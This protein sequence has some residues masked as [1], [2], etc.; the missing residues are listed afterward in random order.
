MKTKLGK[1]IG[2]ILSMLMMFSVAACGDKDKGG[3]GTDGDN[4]GTGP[5][6]PV[7]A[8]ERADYLAR[9]VD[10]HYATYNANGDVAVA[11]YYNALEGG[12]DGL[13]NCYEYS[14]MIDMANY[15]VEISAGEDKTYYTKLLN[16]YVDGLKFFRGSGNQTST[17]G[18]RYWEKLHG[19]QRK[20]EPD[21]GDVSGINLVYDDLMWI[22]RD[23]L[24]AYQNTGDRK[25]VTEAEYLTMNCLDGWDSTKGGIGGITWGPGYGSK[26]SCSNAPIIS[27]LSQLAEIY[28][29][30]DATVTAEETVFT[31]QT[32]GQDK[33]QWNNMVGMKK[34]DYYLYWAKQVYEFTYNYLRNDDNTFADALWMTETILK[35]QAAPGG[36]YKHFNDKPNNIDRYKFTYNTGAMVSGAAWLYKLTGDEEYLMQA[37]KMAEGAYR[38]FVKTV[39][40]DGK[41]MQMY[42]CRTTLYFNTVLM[43]GYMDLADASKAKNADENAAVQAEVKKYAGVF[44]SGLDYAFENY[45]T[46]RSLP[47]NLLQGWLYATGSGQT[48]D[49]HKDVKDG[50]SAPILYAMI[51]V[52]K[53]AH[54]AL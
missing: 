35:D 39:T 4:T 5:S 16:G 49:T 21:T 43:R 54:G 7:T 17:H 50:A 14:S 15:M 38:Y 45:M 31:E 1:G 11:G 24:H 27:A 20:S 53:N 29:D 42:D 18:T 52:Y 9:G 36:S 48:F 34:Y 37:R 41:E 25:Y 32:F 44:K 6:N 47:H 8:A 3:A 12:T 33:V 51:A 2:V 26:H 28:K 22:V 23:F 13:A 46:G 40:V 19:V 30:S 10:A